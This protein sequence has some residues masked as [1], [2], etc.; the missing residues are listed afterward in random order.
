MLGLFG[1]FSLFHDIDL[2]SSY[3][4]NTWICTRTPRLDDYIDWFCLD[5]G[6][7]D[8]RAFCKAVDAAP[9]LSCVVAFLAPAVRPK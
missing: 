1:M 3:S 4:L 2:G 6:T 5:P 7:P 9:G 8:P